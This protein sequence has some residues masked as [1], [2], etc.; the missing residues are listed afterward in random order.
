MNH[1][2]KVL[3]WF[4]FFIEFKLYAPIAILYFAEITGSFALGMSIFSVAVVSGA[5]FEIPTGILSDRLRRRKTIILGAF[6]SVIF[7]TLY[8]IGISYWILVIGA[9][10]EGLAMSLFSG[11]NE[12]LLHESITEEGKESEYAQHLGA[13]SKMLSIGLA[14]SSGLAIVFIFFWP[15]KLLFWLSVIPQI[16]CLV[17]AF[18]VREPKIHLDESGNVYRHL[19]IAFVEFVRNRKLRYLSVASIVV[20]GFG[21]ASFQFQPAFYATVW[22]TWAI[23]IAKMISFSGAAVSFHYAGRIIERF[24]VFKILITGVIYG[25]VIAVFAALAPTILSPLLMSSTAVIFGLASVANSTLFQKEF[26]KEQRATMGSLNA[27]AGSLVFGVVSIT[28][29]LIGDF[30]SPGKAIAILQIFIF[31]NVIIYHKLS[32][33]Y[34]V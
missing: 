27:F 13:T 19:K 5:L 21:Q 31:T 18:F 10:F 20:S 29:G 25:R 26:K 12:A 4:N 23:P 9:I 17:L 1:N 30:L 22:P 16:I 11:N 6:F 2:I 34:K 3:K 8:A 14:I 32:K 33:I 7:I 28:V 24:N 15:F